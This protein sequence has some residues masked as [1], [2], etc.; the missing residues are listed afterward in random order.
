MSEA[1]LPN[2]I[3]KSGTDRF[4]QCFSAA[5][6]FIRNLN[7][8][9]GERKKLV[10]HNTDNRNDLINQNLYGV[11]N[12]VSYLEVKPQS[13]KQT[14]AADYEILNGKKVGFDATSPRF[15]FN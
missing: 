2:S 9:S 8:K 4:V 15:N 3:F 14:R 7:T 12:K 13:V 6:P 10:S 1:K 5:N 11:E